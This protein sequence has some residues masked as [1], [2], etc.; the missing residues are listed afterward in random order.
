MRKSRCCIGGTQDEIVLLGFSIPPGVPGGTVRL[1]LVNKLP[2]I[3]SGL[4][5]EGLDQGGPFHIALDVPDVEVVEITEGTGKVGNPGKLVGTWVGRLEAVEEGIECGT[6]VRVEQL[7]SEVKAGEGISGG[8]RCDL[9]HSVAG[10]SESGNSGREGA[11]DCWGWRNDT[12][13]VSIGSMIRQS[14]ATY[15]RPTSH[16]SAAF[17]F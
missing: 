17:Y 4:G 9:D 5:A 13:S 3:R 15:H 8:R 1:T 2:V 12:W 6:A 7:G 14:S 11:L 10:C 16:Q